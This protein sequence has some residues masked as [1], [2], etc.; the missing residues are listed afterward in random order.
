M[1]VAHLLT[2]AKSGGLA[3]L[4]WEETMPALLEGRVHKLVLVDRLRKHGRSCPGGHVTA[5]RARVCPRCQEPVPA[6]R[7]LTEAAVGAALDTQASVEMVRGSAAQH[8]RL[9]GGIGAILRY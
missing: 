4:G 3:T 8:L 1:V 9:E 7:D 6:S 2:A 5:G